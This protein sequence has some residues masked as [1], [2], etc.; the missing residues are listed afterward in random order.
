[1]TTWCRPGPGAWPASQSNSRTL[2][3][4]PPANHGCGELGEVTQLE[5]VTML[6]LVNRAALESLIPKAQLLIEAWSRHHYASG[7]LAVDLT[8][9]ADDATELGLLD[10][11]RL[12]SG[13]SRTSSRPR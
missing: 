13:I 9:A 4:A 2:S 10:F 8:A 3:G 11:E 7:R 5:P 12:G 6:R 1:M